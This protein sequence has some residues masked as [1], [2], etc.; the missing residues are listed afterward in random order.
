MKNFLRYLLV[1]SL[2][3]AYAQEKKTLTLEDAVFG[4]QK[5]LYPEDL[6]NLQWA[7]DAP[8]FLYRTD[9][10]LVIRRPSGDTLRL[11]TKNDLSRAVENIKRLPWVEK[12]TSEYIA[13]RKDTAYIFFDYNQNKIQKVSFPRGARNFDIESR[14]RYVAYTLENNLYVAMPDGKQIPVAVSEDKNI[15]S[16]QAIARS[17]FGITKGTFWSPSGRYLAFYQKD[18]SDVDEYPLV[19][20]TQTPAKHVPIKYPMNGRGSEEPGVGVFDTRTGK[21]V[22][23]KLFDKAGKYHYATNLTWDPR[24]TYI[25]LAELNRDQNHMWFNKYAVED[26]AFLQTLFEETNEKWVEPEHPGYFVPGKTEFVWMSERDGFMN[27]YLY[28]A[29][30]GK[31]LR[32]LTANRWVM[33]D[34][35]GFTSDGKYVLA[36][37]T[38][39]DPRETHLFRIKIST[40]YQTALTQRPGTHS[41]QVSPDGKY[42]LDNFSSVDVPRIVSVGSVFRKKGRLTLLEAADPLAPYGLRKP[43]MVSLKGEFT[44]ILYGRLIKPSHFDPAKKYPVLIYVYGGPHVQLVTNSWMGGASLWMYWLAEQ[45]YIIFTLDNHGSMNRGFEFESVIY[46][47]LGEIEAKDQMYGVAYLRMLPYTDPLRMA[48]HG[49]SYGGYMTLTLMTEYPE[50]FTTGVAGGPVTDWKWYEVMYGERYMDTYKDN[51]EGFKKTSILNKIQNLEGKLLTIHGYMDDV[52]VPQ[53]NIALHDEAIR[54]GI[55]MDFYLYP[56][57]KH[58]VRGKRR[59]HLMRKMLQYIMENNR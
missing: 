2:M 32:Q 44:D 24:E 8:L 50:A 26:G 3:A 47:R 15:V 36:A 48:V 49:W 33:K 54:K 17:E 35:K 4:W 57:D 59:L 46:R 7:E 10:A 37:G 11:I 45:G 21:T 9:S 53:H 29:D 56:R 30:S 19:D 38:G 6:L 16:G 5:G 40:G 23:L 39:P 51:P 12:F 13:F 18:E 31:L 55:Q 34:V 42:F 20:I 22:Y 28:D 52:V 25:Y 43:E 58:G 14:S 41:V 1:F 27:L